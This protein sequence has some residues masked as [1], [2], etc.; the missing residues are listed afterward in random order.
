MRTA[1]KKL[2]GL[3]IS[4]WGMVE[5]NRADNLEAEA[6]KRHRIADSI[7]PRGWV[8]VDDGGDLVGAEN[9]SGMQ[10]T[11]WR[12]LPEGPRAEKPS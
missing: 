4:S 10:P 8:W 7:D 1:I 5:H 9:S 6:K 11:H 3:F 2:V 12:C